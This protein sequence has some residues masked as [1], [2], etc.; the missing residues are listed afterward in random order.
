MRVWAIQ[1]DGTNADQI[2]EE[3]DC[4]TAISIEKTEEGWIFADNEDVFNIEIGDYITS[5][6]YSKWSPQQKDYFE[7]EHIEVPNED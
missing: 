4:G 3:L 5:N 2:L 6:L 7:S 1:F